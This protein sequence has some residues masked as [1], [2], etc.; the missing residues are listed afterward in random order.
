M[1]MEITSQHSNKL[2]K[3]APEGGAKVHLDDNINLLRLGDKNGS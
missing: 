2:I 1:E 3:I